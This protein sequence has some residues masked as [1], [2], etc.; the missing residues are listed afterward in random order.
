MIVNQRDDDV[1]L[2][3]HNVVGTGDSVRDNTERIV[4]TNQGLFL[5]AKQAIK[6]RVMGVPSEL[7]CRDPHHVKVFFSI[8][9]RSDMGVVVGCINVKIPV[10]SGDH[11]ED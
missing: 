11:H 2:E 8:L 6:T 3:Y 5:F 10:I 4:G 1:R 7:F 9:H